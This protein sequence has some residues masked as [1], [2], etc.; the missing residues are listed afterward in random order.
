MSTT[1]AHLLFILMPLSA[2]T[3][4]L[5]ACA[6]SPSSANTVSRSDTGR[7]HSVERGEVVYVRQVT[8]EGEAR[9]G[10]AVAGG[11]LG[12]AVGNTIGSGSGRTLARAGGTVAGAAAGSAVERAATTVQ[13]VEVS[14]ELQSGEVVV[15]IQAA[16]EIFEVGDQVRVL[17]RGDGQVRVLQ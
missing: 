9:G 10:G 11:V 5:G 1:R 8:I 13:G 16:D 4:G 17:R 3:I 12:W 7:A 15:I 2:A 6:S 14:V